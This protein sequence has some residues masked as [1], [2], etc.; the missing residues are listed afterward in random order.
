MGWRR[1]HDSRIDSK[2]RNPIELADVASRRTSE[3]QVVPYSSRRCWVARACW[4]HS[5]TAVPANSANAWCTWWRGAEIRSW[6]A[7]YRV[8]CIS[9]ALNGAT[10]KRDSCRA[11][12]YARDRKL[13]FCSLKSLITAKLMTLSCAHSSS[14]SSSPRDNDCSNDWTNRM[15]SWATSL[16]DFFFKVL[17]ILCKTLTNY[18]I[19]IVNLAQKFIKIKTK[20]YKDKRKKIFF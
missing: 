9:A 7:S 4:V 13:T 17:R 10:R 15:F 16:I 3:D 11:C 1:E 8:A 2:P 6:T 12:E 20:F 19:C 5:C 18:T 14:S